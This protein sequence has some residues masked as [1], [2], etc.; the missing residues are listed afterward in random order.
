[1]WLINSYAQR[2]KLEGKLTVFCKQYTDCIIIIIVGIFFLL[3]S[4]YALHKAYPI[5]SSNG[6]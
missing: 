6:Q 1:M 2:H 5:H 4:K 3:A